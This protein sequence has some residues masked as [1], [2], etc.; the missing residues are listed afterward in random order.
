MSANVLL[1]SLAADP[2]TR[3]PNH[4]AS[5]RLQLNRHSNP[6]G[7]RFRRIHWGGRDLQ[8]ARN[9]C[10]AQPHATDGPLRAANVLDSSCARWVVAEPGRG[11]GYQPGCPRCSGI[12]ASGMDWTGPPSRG[13]PVPRRWRPAGLQKRVGVDDGLVIGRTGHH[14]AFGEQS[15]QTQMVPGHDDAG[16]F[17]DDPRIVGQHSGR[18]AGRASVEPPSRRCRR[19]GRSSLRRHGTCQTGSTTALAA[20]DDET[21]LPPVFGTPHRPTDTTPKAGSFSAPVK[22]V[23]AVN[24]GVADKL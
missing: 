15:I 9:A 19:G 14:S 20:G 10:A 24:S 18:A 2:T 7:Q 22:A 17:A 4:A 11:V 13:R 5:A 23:A 1:G 16:F 6:L 3:I 12:S 8:S 21:R